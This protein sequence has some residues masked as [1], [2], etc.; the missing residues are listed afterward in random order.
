MKKLLDRIAGLE[1]ISAELEPDQF[2]RKKFNDEI[3][4]FAEEFIKSLVIRPAYT[5]GNA[6]AEKL[7]IKRKKQSLSNLLEIYT[8][9]VVERGIVASSGGHLGYIPGGGI[10]T[11]ALADYIADITNEYA[12]IHFGSPGAVTME[13]ELINWMKGIFGFPA[14][15]HRQFSIWWV[16]CQLNSLNCGEG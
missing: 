5:K 9:E 14:R 7:S 13:N 4:A 15:C 8:E 6:I 10:F 3:N 12:G 2:Q 1:K 16:Y 11:S